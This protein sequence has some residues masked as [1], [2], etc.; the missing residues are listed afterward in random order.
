MIGAPPAVFGTKGRIY[1]YYGSYSPDANPDVVITGT[2]QYFGRAMAPAGDINNDGF[3]D[4]I[5]CSPGVGLEV[6][7]GFVYI[8]CGGANMDTIADIIIK[9]HDPDPG[10]GV[11]VSGAGDLNKDGYD[12]ILVGDGEKVYGYY[13]GRHMDNTPDFILEGNGKSPGDYGRSLSLAG[14]VNKDGI[15]D[16]LVGDRSSN[17]VGTSM[18]RVYI[19]SFYLE[20]D[21][22]IDGQESLWNQNYP[23][24]FNTSTTI[25]YYLIKTGKVVVKILSTTGQEL[26]VLANGP[27]DVGLHRIIWQP[28]GLPAGVY[29][30]I[31]KTSENSVTR[32]MVLQK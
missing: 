25:E 4:I 9:K 1:I 30:C 2:P 19:Y 29:F 18:G 12:D 26:E 22:I 32:K 6:D 15:V 13:G 10:F 14:D 16:I 5:V 28:E 17:A 24:P 11:G 23:N 21:V 20:P 8:Y 7:T 3:D 31:I 27:Q